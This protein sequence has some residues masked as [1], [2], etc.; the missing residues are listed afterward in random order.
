MSPEQADL[1]G[2]DVDT[3]T[4]VYSLGVMLYE[5]LVGALPF[6]PKALRKAGYAEIQRIIREEEP[7][8]PTTRLSG[9]GQAGQEVARRRRSDLRTLTRLLR[10]DLEWIT[11]KALDKDRTQRYASASEFAMDIG[12]HLGNEPVNAGPPSTVYRVRK[13]VRRHSAKVAAAAALLIT[14]VAGLAASTMLYVRADRERAAQEWEAYKS[15]LAAARSEIDAGRR[16]EARALLRRSPKQLRGWEW[17]YLYWLSDTSIVTLNTGE[18]P[19]TNIGFSPDASRLFVSTPTAVHVWEM[20]TFRRLADY[21]PFPRIVAMTRDGTKLVCTGVAPGSVE[22]LET[23]TGKKLVAIQGQGSQMVGFAFSSDGSRLATRN[24]KDEIQLW[25]VEDGKLLVTIHAPKPQVGRPGGVGQ[26]VIALS[27]DGHRLASSNGSQILMWDATTGHQVANMDNHGL[28]QGLTFNAQGTRLFSVADSIRIWNSVSGEPIDKL[29]Q[30]ASTY[31]C[32][33]ESPDGTRVAGAS[34]HR[35]LH[36]WNRASGMPITTT[37]LAAPRPNNHSDLAYSPDGKFLVHASRDQVRIWDGATYGQ[38][39]RFA[40][41]SFRSI[42][43]SHDGKSLGVGDGDELEI[44]DSRTGNTLQSWNPGEGAVTAVAYHPQDEIVASG[45]ENGSIG[46][47]NPASGSRLLRIQ[48]HEVSVTSLAFSP[49]GKELASGSGRWGLRQPTSKETLCLWDVNSGRNRFSRPLAGTA[50][51]LD[52][53]PDGKT[54]LVTLTTYLPG[55]RA[56]QIDP[57]S[58]TD[59][60]FPLQGLSDLRWPPYEGVFSKGGGV[61]SGRRTLGCQDR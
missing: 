33:A 55:S 31:L 17:N 12:R 40:K 7:P 60:P 61:D 36:I 54:L 32:V 24:L 15:N 3:T 52:F 41:T 21:G 58:G 14:L 20:G 44:V 47:W 4:D 37:P 29:Y 34:W 25:R 13:F 51:F 42:V 23:L 6:D 9:M 38:F 10:G 28:V 45:F 50:Q 22:I 16:E 43:L 19:A 30:S 49:E 35:E 1:T 5:L 2:L 39:L 8:R 48:G 18:G 57:R 53:S 27:P 26:E 11:M 46:L 59:L 56:F